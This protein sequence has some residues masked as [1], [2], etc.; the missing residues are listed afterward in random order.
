MENG[1]WRTWNSHKATVHLNDDAIKRL[2]FTLAVHWSLHLAFISYFRCRLPIPAAAAT[3]S[4]FPFHRLR[5]IDAVG[6]YG[7]L[8]CSNFNEPPPRVVAICCFNAAVP[9]CM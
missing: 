2:G 5:I 9:G 6:R 1:A 7:H 3:L 8:H 4:A